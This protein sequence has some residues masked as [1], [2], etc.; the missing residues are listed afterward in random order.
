M[1]CI[2]FEPYVTCSVRSQQLRRLEARRREITEQEQ[3]KLPSGS[4]MSKGSARFAAELAGTDVVSPAA[5]SPCS[6]PA[7]GFPAHSLRR[8]P[9][10]LNA[11]VRRQATRFTAWDKQKA[12]KAVERRAASVDRFGGEKRM[13]SAE[14]IAESLGRL[15]EWERRR[16]GKLT[17]RHEVSHNPSSFPQSL[18]IWPISCHLEISRSVLD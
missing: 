7:L 5:P 12:A 2:L 11:F 10:E 6:S 16:Q 14:Q 18:H 15:E 8:P 9:K 13:V 17:E 1:L 4:H 3:G